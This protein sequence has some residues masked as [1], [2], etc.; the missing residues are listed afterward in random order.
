MIGMLMSSWYLLG[1]DF[2]SNGEV[3]RSL[4]LCLRVSVCDGCWTRVCLVHFGV[5][6]CWDSAIAAKSDFRGVSKACCSSAASES[7][8]SSICV[9]AG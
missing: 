6:W 7:E 8:E 5:L 3:L 2:I 9:T 4:V 1:D